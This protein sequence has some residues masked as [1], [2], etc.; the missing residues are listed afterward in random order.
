MGEP[1]ND[2]ATGDPEDGGGTRPEGG[3]RRHRGDTEM[4][5][6]EHLEE[7]RWTVGRSLLAFI[8]GVAVVA[9][10][11][12]DVAEFLQMPLVRAYGSS[13]AALE[14]L[15]T[16]RPMGV[17]SVFLQ[18]MLLGGLTLSMPFA[19]Y[20]L[21]CFVAP[22][23]TERERAVLRPSCLAAFLL[24][25]GGVAFA[26]FVILPLTL[27]FSVRFNEFFNFSLFWAASEY[28]NMIVWFSIA[29]GVFFQFPLLI[30]LLVY[31]E[32]VPVAKLR[33]LRRGVFVGLLVF[34]AVL[35]PGGD[36]VSLPLTAGALYGLYELA[37][38]V[39][40]RVER[41]KRRAAFDEW[42]E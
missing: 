25:L 41:R 17:F 3:R 15:I 8:V 9:V 23:L 16:Y 35:T 12:R 32:V 28:Y 42:R 10:F 33:A 2:E 4:T 13:E 18:I 36:F 22:G 30:L 38:W 7:F 34:A 27:G 20:F 40:G 39:G 6:L 5:F 31:L 21:A 1:R 26:F 37:I 29:T 19:L 14:N 24:F 11:M